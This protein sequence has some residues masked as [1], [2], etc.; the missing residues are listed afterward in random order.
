M[1]SFRRRNLL[2]TIIDLL[3][4]IIS[5]GLNIDGFLQP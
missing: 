4:D 3:S 2:I 1:Y 5:F